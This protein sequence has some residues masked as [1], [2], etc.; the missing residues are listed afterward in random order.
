MIVGYSH[1]SAIDDCL[2]SSGC[3]RCHI[4]VPSSCP[5]DKLHTFLIRVM[6]LA[7]VRGRQNKSKAEFGTGL[8]R[9]LL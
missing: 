5:V 9:L 8:A 6:L 3:L 4:Y 2:R 1:R 7:P